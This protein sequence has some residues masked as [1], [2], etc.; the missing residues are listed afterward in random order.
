MCCRRRDKTVW[1]QVQYIAQA[2]APP[3]RTNDNPNPPQPPIPGVT[4]P[5][6]SEP[7]RTCNR[8]RPP[9]PGR[10][11]AALP[12]H[13]SVGCHAGT[14]AHESRERYSV[15]LEFARLRSAVYPKHQRTHPN[16]DFQLSRSMSMTWPCG[17]QAPCRF[18]SNSATRRPEACGLRNIYQYTTE[19]IFR[20]NQLIISSNVRARAR[21]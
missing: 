17:R 3:P 16:R 4:Y 1:T 2:Q 21:S 12:V 7:G 9:L 6:Y 13:I 8:V 15:V 10:S 19:G 18:V 14:A 11:A 20:Q 5:E